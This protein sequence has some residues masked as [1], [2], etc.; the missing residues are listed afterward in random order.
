M[1]HASVVACTGTLV[2]WDCVDAG[3][4][5]AT[6]IAGTPRRRHI[7]LVNIRA[8]E[9]C[10]GVATLA[11]AP[12][13]TWQVCTSAV[14][15]AW[16]ARTFINVFALLTAAQIADNTLA[17][18]GSSRVCACRVR[19]AVVRAICAFV[20]LCALHT[21]PCPSS[22]ARTRETSQSVTTPGLGVAGLRVGVAFVDVTTR[23]SVS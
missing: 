12:E 21:V 6:W 22:V 1:E 13:R 10:P 4:T 5:Q 14:A 15:T 8:D 11:S 16:L 17:L 18:P 7:A 2:E 9:A 23:H 3:S 20:D 19:V